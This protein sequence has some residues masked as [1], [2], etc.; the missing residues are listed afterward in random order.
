MAEKMVRRFANVNTYYTH[1]KADFGTGRTINL[2]VYAVNVYAQQTFKVAKT[3]TLELSGFYSSP[4]IWQGTFK[5][6]S[7]WSVDWGIQQTLFKG[8]ATAK[9]TV[10]DIFQSLRY[11]GTSDFA[12][13]YMHVHGG[14][15]SRQFRLSFIYRFGNTKVKSARQR[16]TGADEENQRV[17]SQGG[18][19]NR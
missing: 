7:I 17:G 19:L 4:S 16:K 2:D 8:N 13:Q 11:S 3:T 18:G 9:A 10:T 15:E 5:S 6:S 1:Y 12:G 14:N